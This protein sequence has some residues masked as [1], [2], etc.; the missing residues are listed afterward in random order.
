MKVLVI[1]NAKSIGSVRALADSKSWCM[2]SGSD[3]G[4]TV[5]Y[6]KSVEFQIAFVMIDHQDNNRFAILS[7][8]RR[9]D[10]GFPIIALIRNDNPE[11][12]AQAWKSGA[13]ICLPFEVNKHELEMA[14]L[15]AIRQTAAVP[16]EVIQ[17]GCLSLDLGKAMLSVN[18]KVI[19]LTKS[20]FLLIE[21]LMLN[22][23]KTVSRDQIMD[24]LYD[25]D[26]FPTNKAIDV[27]V[28][29]VRAKLQKLGV[30]S[31]AIKS[32]YGFGYRLEVPVLLD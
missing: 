27:M 2:V 5:Y 9:E 12:R 28:Y 15:A 8:L 19:T 3:F 23:G 20:Q 16:S 31:N 13:L 22:R 14:A 17:Y 29:K 1:G 18:D 24:H 7:A 26:T 21:K 32:V 30:F 4:D 25:F 6:A 10:V 11:E